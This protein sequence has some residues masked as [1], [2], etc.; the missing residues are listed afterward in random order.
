M[1][2][3]STHQQPADQFAIEKA[4]R[5]DLPKILD[6]LTSDFLVTEPLGVALAIKREEA[7]EFFEGKFQ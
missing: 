1:L 6:F 7:I 3:D 2:N 4:T 5:E